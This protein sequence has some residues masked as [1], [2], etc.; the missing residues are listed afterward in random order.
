MLQDRQRDEVI[1]AIMAFIAEQS[2]VATR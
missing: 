1:A 2:A